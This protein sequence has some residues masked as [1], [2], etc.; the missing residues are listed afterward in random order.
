MTLTDF[1][2]AYHAWLEAGAPTADS[3]FSRHVGLSRIARVKAH[4]A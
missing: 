4:L 2:R 3:I 1:Y